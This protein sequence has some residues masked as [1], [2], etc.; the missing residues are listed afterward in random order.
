M[1]FVAEN[2]QNIFKEEKVAILFGPRPR[3]LF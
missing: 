2:S 3:I 1:G